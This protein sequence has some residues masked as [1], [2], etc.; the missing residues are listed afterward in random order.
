MLAVQ[1]TDAVFIGGGN[2]FRLLTKMYETK[3]VEA[4][5]ARCDDGMPYIGTSAGS[6]VATPSI[7]TTNDM[8]IVYPPSFDALRLFP[9]QINAHFIDSDPKSTHMGETREDRYV[10]VCVLCVLCVAMSENV[11]WC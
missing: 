10:C 7:R 1:I 9:Y 6:N 11:K 2:T 4:I 8:P 3:I 5:R